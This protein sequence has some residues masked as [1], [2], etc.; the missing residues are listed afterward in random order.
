MFTSRVTGKKK[1]FNSSFK[2]AIGELWY[3]DFKMN[4][5]RCAIRHR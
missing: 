3:C 2:T 1:L 4:M 5:I